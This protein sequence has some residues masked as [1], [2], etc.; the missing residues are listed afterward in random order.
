MVVIVMVFAIHHSMHLR[1]D[2][3]DPV[4]GLLADR[5]SHRAMVVVPLLAESITYMG[6]ANVKTSLGAIAHRAG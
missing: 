3:P 5:A 6:F 1:V 2:T 4:C